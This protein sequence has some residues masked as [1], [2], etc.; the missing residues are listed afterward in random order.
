[1]ETIV[2]DLGETKLRFGIAGE[3]E[4]TSKIPN[5][6]G[7][8]ED[9]TYVGEKA[10]KK[11]TELKDI[12][13]TVCNKKITNEES[14]EK[15]LKKVL[16]SEKFNSKRESILVTES[17]FTKN[18]QRKY[19]A[20]ILFEKYNFGYVSMIESPLLGLYSTGYNSGIA[21]ESGTSMTTVCHFKEDKLD[22]KSIEKLKIGGKQITE[23]LQ[24][25]LEEKE[26]KIVLPFHVC[27]E[28]KEKNAMIKTD[29]KDIK[30]T[31]KLP[32]GEKIKLG[33]ELYKCTKVLFKPSLLGLES[34][35]IHKILE[36]SLSKYKSDVFL[37]GG[38]TMLIGDS[39]KMGLQKKIKQNFRCVT[40]P[41]RETSVWIGGSIIA[42]LS[43][44]NTT[45]NL[46]SKKEYK[47]DQYLKKFK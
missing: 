43:S 27:N 4:P 16:K 21:V 45:N 15:I 36:K 8:I 12:E 46:I 41:E 28:I 7:K 25:L 35:G 31:Y 37:F 3:D 42:S 39:F 30:T 20:E 6:V 32:D 9:K 24:K 38:N 14:F 10:F 18:S 33:N 19:L 44:Y 11:I 29:P 22:K 5:L 26:E 34:E 2:F 47:D 13:S 23:N 17:L 40:S 1:M